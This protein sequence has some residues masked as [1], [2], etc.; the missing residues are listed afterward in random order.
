MNYVGSFLKQLRKA[1]GMTLIEVRAQTGISVS[2]LSDIENGKG[3]PSPEYRRKLCVL[4]GVEEHELFRG[5]E[6]LVCSES[7]PYMAVTSDSPVI[8]AALTDADA[9][10]TLL[11]V[12]GADHERKKLTLSVVRAL[13]H[14]PLEKL[15][16]VA[17]L[18]G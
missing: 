15:K 8:R 18:I 2:R 14:I 16:A 13:R 7:E 12:H 5:K 11:A 4:F 17:A 6:H 3:E 1:R 10:E 9:V